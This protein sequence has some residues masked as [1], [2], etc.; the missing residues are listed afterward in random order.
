MG[1]R[2]RGAG[3]ER[4]LDTR[5]RPD[6]STMPGTLE[7]SGMFISVIMQSGNGNRPTSELSSGLS[8]EKSDSLKSSLMMSLLL[9]RLEGGGGVCFL[10]LKL[11]RDETLRNGL[12][13][14]KA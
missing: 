1:I 10:E 13:E 4:T 8:S 7:S 2:E 6:L 11:G 14:V 9:S 5:S 12:G 3:E